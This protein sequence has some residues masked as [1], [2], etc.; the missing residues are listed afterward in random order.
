MTTEALTIW[1]NPTRK[2]E[3]PIIEC[4]EWSVEVLVDGKQVDEAM[5]TKFRERM[6]KTSPSEN[7]QHGA[8]IE[9]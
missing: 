8:K 3:E 1:C 2:A 6:Q 7:H 4:G 9:V 5:K